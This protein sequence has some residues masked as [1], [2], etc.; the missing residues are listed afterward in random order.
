[1]NWSALR[2]FTAVLLTGVALTAAGTLGTSTPAFSAA[3]ARGAVR[4]ENKALVEAVNGAQAD[5]K[6]GKYADALAKAK[7]ADAIQGKPAQLTG[8]IHQMIVA[9]A[10]QAKDYNSALT[11]VEKM[12]AAGEGNKT[13]LLGQAFA[14]S[15]QAGNQTRAMT[16]ADQMGTN[17]TPQIRLSLASGYA[18][19]KKYK[20]A[21]DEVQPLRASPTE[22]LLLFLQNTYNEMGDAAN[23]RASL[24]Q[25]VANYPKPQ[26]WHDLLQLARNE[27]GLNDEQ[28]LDILRLRL[29]VGDLKTESDY[30]EMAQL[31]LVAAYPYE[32][33]TILDKAAAAKLLSGERSERLIKMTNDR[34][35]ADKMA[36]A[37]LQ[38]KA[39]DPNNRVKL[40]L[41]YWTYGKNQEAEEAIRASMKAKLADPE[42]AKMALGH[43]LLSTGK[44]PEAV[45]AFN[46]VARN[47]KQAGIARLW[48]IFARQT[49]AKV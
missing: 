16:Y 31:A 36:L 7:V 11:Q 29:A 25:L 49:P 40:G 34:V 19:A 37:E 18:K 43:V 2:A 5:A 48:S 8:Q 3:A 46:S 27:R 21:I 39:G 10:V 20:E 1:M 44:R 33:K 22:P 38:K 28:S 9:Y 6:A 35:N 24:E 47:S 32:A 15:M 26:Y 45:Q 42:A 4:V 14:I 17:K 41:V 23:R 13:E 30:S 12:I